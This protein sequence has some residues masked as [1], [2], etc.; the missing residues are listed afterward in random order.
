MSAAPDTQGSDERK[1]KQVGTR[2]IR[3]DGLDK[4]TGRARFGADLYAPGMLHGVFVRSPHAHARIRSID[5]S[6]AEK[7]PGVRAVITA[8]DLPDIPMQW[9][10]AGPA[11]VDFGANS[12]TIL[13]REKVLYHGHAFAAVAASSAEIAREAGKLIE[14]DWEVLA[15][16]LSIAEA[17]APDAPILHEGQ[18]TE[19]ADPKPEGDTNISSQVR[20]DGGDLEAGF[21]EADVIVEG[22]FETPM[23]HQGYIEPHACLANARE[24]GT[25]EIW[26]ATQGAFGV[27]SEVAS[28]TGTDA[29]KIKVTPSEIGGGFGGKI[30]V[31]LEP[32]ALQ[33]SRK[34]GRPVKMVMSREEVFRGTGPT[35]GSRMHAKIGAKADGTIVAGQIRLEFEAGAF[36][37]SPVGAAC[38]TAFAPYKIPN[39]EIFGLEVV[40]NKP[41]VAAYRAPGAPMA[42]LMV[43]SLVDELAR[44]LERD[45]IDLRLQ[46]A[47]EEGDRAPY[48]PVFG[49]IGFKE[50]LEAMREHPHYKAPLGPNQGRGVAAGFWFNAGMQSS[51]TVSVN[52]DGSAVVRTGNPDIGGSRAS[53]ALMCAE[54]LGIDV[55]RV[56]PMVGDTDAVGYCDA[57]GG[58]RVTYATGMAVIE[59]TRQVIDHL[60]ARAATIWDIELDAV[61]WQDGNAVA[62]NG[63]AEKGSLSLEEI[64][65]QMRMT[66]GPIVASASCSPP[67]A[68]PG[69]GVHCCDLE[70]DPETGVSRVV[71]YTVVQ[72]AGK[73]IHPTYVEGQFQGGAVQG[74]G[75]A[76]NE[77]YLWDAEGKVENPGFLDY[78]IPV[79]SD[80]PMIETVIV[81]KPNPLH[82]YGVRGVGETPIVPP[83]PTVVNAMCDATGI[84][85][86]RVPMS[87][88]RV[89]AAIEGG[90]D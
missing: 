71:R 16:V 23:V 31:Y 30:P 24:D 53:M 62:I 20:F 38:M 54:E 43:E 4:V 50:C 51:A 10:Q 6:K 8:A 33:L 86:D 3:H 65:A 56:R 59:A 44:K 39:F 67:A 52:D 41:R 70:V 68:G 22:S 82:P 89:L 35:S 58:S 46:N 74:I 83:L 85:F 80:L 61:E 73:A 18:L 76:L 26:C 25:C 7:V 15:P 87:P 42:A 49:P 21:S 72:D 13:A 88:P 29:S 90:S 78:R 37:G 28:I 11:G 34:A 55:T 40:V 9:I 5:T 75:W 27:K 64:A 60:R 84:R 14:V 19:G 17:M 81:E 66:G 69:F 36:R 77:E 63:S 12:R 48:G 45:P 2:P 1:F 32:A 57:T 79:A 47:V